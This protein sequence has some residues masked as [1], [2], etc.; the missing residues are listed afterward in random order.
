MN[1]QQKRHKRYM[2]AWAVVRAQVLERDHHE[3]LICGKRETTAVHHIL[4]R[5]AH[6]ELR[7]DPRNLCL[8]C[9]THHDSNANTFAM[10]VDLLHKMKDKHPEYDYSQPPFAAYLENENER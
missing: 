1:P 7:L 5:G 10:I 3:C 6:P 4:S 9:V 2:K 8:L